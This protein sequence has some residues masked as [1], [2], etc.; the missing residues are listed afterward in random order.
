MGKWLAGL[1]GALLL[2]TGLARAAEAIPN[3]DCLVCHEDK[4]LTKTNANGTVKLL[5]VEVAR[6][7]RSVHQSN[8]CVNCHADLTAQ[9]PDD[10]VPAKPPVCVG[11]HDVQPKHEAAAQSSCYDYFHEIC[12]FMGNG[13]CLREA[14]HHFDYPMDVIL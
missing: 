2:L 13:S 7:A 8:A 10:N 1:G 4:T 14:I 11:C 12:S 5:F 3:A 9:H 6:L